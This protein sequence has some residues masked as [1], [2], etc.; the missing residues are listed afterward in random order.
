MVD[1]TEIGYIYLM[2]DWSR[3]LKK[4]FFQLT[5]TLIRTVLVIHFRINPP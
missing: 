3:Q 5:G 1:K 4:S 2:M